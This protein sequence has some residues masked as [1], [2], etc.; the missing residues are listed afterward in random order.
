MLG[1]GVQRLF[2]IR[3]CINNIQI[4]YDGTASVWKSLCRW[5]D[6]KEAV[7]GAPRQGRD[8]I[9]SKFNELYEY[10]HGFGPRGFL[11]NS[12]LNNNQRN[13]FILRLMAYRRQH[14]TMD[15]VGA[16][17]GHLKIVNH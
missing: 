15:A 13:R 17:D 10:V 16:G 9:A 4:G 2:M 3:F 7:N 8:Q 5:I 12:F 6:V 11:Y 14:R 1:L